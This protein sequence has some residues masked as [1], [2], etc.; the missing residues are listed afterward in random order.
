MAA[1]EPAVAAPGKAPNKEEHDPKLTNGF[2]HSQNEKVDGGV[3]RNPT[4]PPHQS[5]AQELKQK[6]SSGGSAGE[7]LSAPPNGASSPRESNGGPGYGAPGGPPGQ[8]PGS[9]YYPGYGH[10]YPPKG[11]P[12]PGYPPQGPPPPSSS[13]GAPTSAA[14]GGPTPTLNSL[15]QDRSQRFPGSYEGGTG[16]PGGPGGP[17]GP[18]AHPYPGW[19]YQGHP[20]YRGQVI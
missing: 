16:P 1:L 15:L 20:N 13:Y 3:P 2:V 19:G 8:Y 10:H 6:M 11:P 5:S 18:G 4:Q 9:P 7:A 12:G 17:P 14:G